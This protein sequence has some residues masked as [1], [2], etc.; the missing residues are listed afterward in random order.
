M[1][2]KSDKYLLKEVTQEKNS[3]QA[4]FNKRNEEFTLRYMGGDHI[5]LLWGNHIV[6]WAW[7][8]SHKGNKNH[9]HLQTGLTNMMKPHLY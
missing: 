3:W 5:L 7:R 6:L 8:M 9:I 1:F 2:D 4:K